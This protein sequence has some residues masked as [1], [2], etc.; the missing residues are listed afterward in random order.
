MGLD[1]DSHRSTAL[2]LPTNLTAERP[3]ELLPEASSSAA[4]SDEALGTRFL[5]LV[6]AAAQPQA[7]LGEILSCGTPKLVSEMPLRVVMAP[8]V[9]VQQLSGFRMLG[10]TIVELL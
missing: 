8:V 2:R 1:A 7:W 4:D 10:E 5:L 9:R 6:W 3:P